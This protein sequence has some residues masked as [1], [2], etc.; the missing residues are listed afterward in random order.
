MAR[1]KK[2]IRDIPFAIRL[3]P[4]L[5][6]HVKEQA[7]RQDDSMNAV[8]VRVLRQWADHDQAPSQPAHP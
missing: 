8:M 3:P 4:A 1:A 2:K 6:A 5:Y 7:D